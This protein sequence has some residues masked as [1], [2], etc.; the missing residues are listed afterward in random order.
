MQPTETLDNYII[1][2]GQGSFWEIFKLRMEDYL[3]LKNE[4]LIMYI[5]KEMSLFL[6]GIICAR[7]EMAI[8]QNRKAAIIFCVVAI[9][10]IVSM[11][12]FKSN[13]IAFFD[14]ENNLIQRI[15]LGL[16]IHINE[17]L[18]GFLYI[19]GFFLLWKINIIQ[20]LLFPLTYPG[21][22]S[23]T[24]YISQSLICAIIFSGF[25]Y[26]GK[27]TPSE[28]VMIAMVI[29]IGQ[30]LLSKL[31]LNYRKYGPLEYLWRQYSK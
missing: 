17:F 19:L 1:I 10:S 22:L 20:K 3:S 24:N 16:I 21:R 11:Y 23:L 25:G 7:K 2:N 5:P 31:W 6:L 28:L 26:Y 9:S 30:L 29:Y 14:Y 18:H 13:I 8:K 27:L 15:I 4:K 12:F